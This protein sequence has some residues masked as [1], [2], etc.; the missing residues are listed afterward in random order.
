MGSGKVTPVFVFLL[1]TCVFCVFVFRFTVV[2]LLIL[3]KSFS[4]FLG[5]PDC[6]AGGMM[7]IM[8]S[9]TSYAW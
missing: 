9:S 8:Y 6:R 7:R 1:Q 4:D 2:V 5:I 3:F